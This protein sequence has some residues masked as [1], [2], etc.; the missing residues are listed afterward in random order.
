MN[1]EGGRLRGEEGDSWRVG[2]V[3][4]S[5]D[6]WG[7]GDPKGQKPEALCLPSGGGCG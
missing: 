1:L 5:R 3:T 6:P 7:A 4:P 2:H